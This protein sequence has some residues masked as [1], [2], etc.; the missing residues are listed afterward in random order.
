MNG[1]T[2]SCERLCA[3]RKAF[4]RR[5]IGENVYLE[6]SVTPTRGQVG[7]LGSGTGRFKGGLI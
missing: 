2:T 1:L 3:A 6:S 4:L 7:W 5:F